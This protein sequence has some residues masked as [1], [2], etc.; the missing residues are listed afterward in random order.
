[1]AR[2]LKGYIADDPATTHQKCP[3]IIVFRKL[4]AGVKTA[5]A[6]A[7]G[8]LTC[9]ALFFGMRSCEYSRVSGERKT[10]IQ[11]L[12]H[13]RFY[14]QNKEIK[15]A[16]DMNLKQITKVTITFHRQ[17]NNTKEADITMHRSNDK[18]LCPVLAWGNIAQRILSY[19]NTDE[20]TPV[21]Y[22]M[23]NSKHYYIQSKEFFPVTFQ[24]M[25]HILGQISICRPV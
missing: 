14:N 6:Q 12:K 25:L 21:N 23:V 2:Q 3:P 24:L 22:V 10:K 15:K 11:Q 13:I 7:I 4:W 9:G 16:K 5:L 20:Q 8:Q 18:K 17:K 19:E 1:M